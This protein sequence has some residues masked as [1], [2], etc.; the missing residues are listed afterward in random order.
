[1]SV[2]DG[3]YRDPFGVHEMRYYADGAPTGHVADGGV[4]TYDLP[5]PPPA[6]SQQADQGRSDPSPPVT[7]A[8]QPTSSGQQPEEQA[9]PHVANV[10]PHGS[11]ASDTDD[12]WTSHLVESAGNITAPRRKRPVIVVAAVVGL[13]VVLV[14]SLAL[15]SGSSGSPAPGAGIAPVS[16]VI[17]AAHTTL[18]HHTSD[19]VLGGSV[20]ARGI[21]VP[22]SGTGQQDLT[23][24][25]FSA[26]VHFDTIRGTSV[27]E[28]ELVVGGH[29]YIGATAN[30]QGISALTGGKHWVDVPVPTDASGSGVG[31]G[32]GDPS[33]QIAILLQRGNSVRPLGSS[34]IDGVAVSG[35][36]ITPSKQTIQQALQQEIA[37][38]KLPNALQQQ[39]QQEEQNPPTGS[40]DVWIDSSNL[41]RRLT[42]HLQLNGQ[43]AGSGTVVMTFRNYGT[44]VSISAPDASDV[45]SYSDFLKDIQ[46]A[47]ASSG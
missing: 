20:T 34:V 11:V 26:D 17:S 30:G 45:T 4:V 3:W 39:L 40:F 7:D 36:Q 16:F 33:S 41:M 25:S 14:T 47:G 13:V 8:E 19:V 46:Y 43:T 21:T 5:P 29:F 23:A 42:V 38:G 12:N 6:A 37:S 18:A 44:P 35:F 24:G 2:P 27:D 22:L 10:A 15:V 31:S 28:R 1:M 9:E 32:T